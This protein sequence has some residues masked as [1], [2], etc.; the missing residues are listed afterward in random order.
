MLPDAE[1]AYADCTSGITLPKKK[2]MKKI[3]HLKKFL[4][5]VQLGDLPTCITD[6]EGLIPEVEKIIADFKAGN[7]SQALSDL[8]AMV[9]D[10]EK[11]YTDCTSGAKHLKT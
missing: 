6:I 8:L 1:K 9:P 7:E 10:A 2:M 5:G 4:G 3:A 11:A